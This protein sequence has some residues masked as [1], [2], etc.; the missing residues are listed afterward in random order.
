[1]K[2]V[3]RIFIIA[4]LNQV[5]SLYRM[6]HIGGLVRNIID[7]TTKF[8]TSQCGNTRDTHYISY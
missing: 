1:M 5:G 3:R 7:F 2:W 6:L 4:K 8:F